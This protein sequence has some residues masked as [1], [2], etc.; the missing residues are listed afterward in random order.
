LGAPPQRGSR[1]DAGATAQD[2]GGTSALRAEAAAGLEELSRIER[3]APV[4]PASQLSQDPR[5]HYHRPH[6][7]RPERR[8]QG[9]P[10][11]PVQPVIE[12]EGAR[13]L[14]AREEKP[15]RRYMSNISQASLFQ[16]SSTNLSC[17]LD[18]LAFDKVELPVLA[19]LALVL[20]MRVAPGGSLQS[21]SVGALTESVRGP[22]VASTS[23]SRPPRRANRGGWWEALPTR[24]LPC[25]TLTPNQVLWI[26]VAMNKFWGDVP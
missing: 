23:P 20:P 8:E 1:R 26:D 12:R 11:G 18:D 16:S 13:E 6:H 21:S 2:A 5:P 14:D 3:P 15:E 25:R 4:D 22:G 17:P 7:G 10:G 19:C 24:A 9:V